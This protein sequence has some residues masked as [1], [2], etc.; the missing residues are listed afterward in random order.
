MYE[1]LGVYGPRWP[2]MGKLAYHVT[3]PVLRWLAS[4]HQFLTLD[5]QYAQERGA[6]LRARLAAGETA[7]VVGL[8]V[9]GHNSG[10]ALVEVSARRGIQLLANNEEERYTQQKHCTLLPQHTI[11]VLR[12]QLAERGLTGNDV[13][14]FVS[15]WDYVEKSASAVR[16]FISELPGS[17][18]MIDGRACPSMNGTHVKQGIHSPAWVA[19]ELGLD[20]PRPVI[21]LRHHDNHAYFSY[22][23]SPFAQTDERVLVAVIDGAG[24]EGAVSLYLAHRNEVRLLYDN[25]SMNDSPAQLYGHLSSALGGWT[26]MS[27]EGRYMGAA[28]WGNGN[29]FTNPYYRELRQLV[30]FAPQGEVFINKRWANWHRAGIFKPYTDALAKVIGLPIPLEKMWNPDAILDV[31]QIEHSPITQDR[32]DKAAALQMVYEDMLFHIIEHWITTLKVKH[33]VLTG[34]GALNCLANMRLLEHFDEAFFERY[35]DLRETRL[36][37]WAPPVPGDAGTPIGAAYH[38]ALRHGGT[39]GAP[40][41]HAFFCGIAPTTDEIDAAL[42]DSSD[43]GARQVGNVTENTGRARVADL[44]AFLISQGA[45]V[46]L[47]QGVA[48]T[49]PRALGHRSILANPCDP[50]TRQHLNRLVKFRELVRP[51]APMA[52]IDAAEQWFELAPGAEARQYN[53]YRYMVLTVAAKPSARAVVP[54]IIHADGTAR[55]QIVMP[56]TDPFTYAYLQAMGR[57]VGVEMS[58]NTSLNVGS[59]IVQTPEQALDALRRSHGLTALLMIGADGS[60]RL[61]W[62]A[63]EKPPKDAGAQLNVWIDRWQRRESHSLSDSIAVES[64]F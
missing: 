35:C 6:A 63:I 59:P 4:R 41:E 12:Q 28:A 42:E 38:F 44:L 43:I 52:T 57:Y 11:R 46:G 62:H 34:G 27:S 33:L 2:R 32:V 50:H 10:T 26:F 20:S 58:V 3:K 16:E 64:G 7:Y 36:Q 37:L 60:A 29:R 39:I 47:F 23:V 13:H 54:A 51:L 1:S 48:E 21:G 9:G 61:A 40:L 45:I 19:R 31:E 30:F 49:G 56:E 17:W 53:A 14:A 55:I 24:D 8:G 5:S 18:G 15:S 22:G 25:R